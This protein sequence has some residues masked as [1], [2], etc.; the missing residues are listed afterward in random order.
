MTGEERAAAVRPPPV[1]G[2]VIEPSEPGAGEPVRLLDLSYDPAGD[3][4]ALH[5]WDFGDGTTS[6]EARPTHR[7]AR[8]GAYTVTLHVTALDGRVAVTSTSVAVVTHD[9]ALTRIRA[10]ERA[11]AGDEVTVVVTIES[12][13]GAEIVQIDLFRQRGLGESAWETTGIQTH[14]IPSG[15]AV[16]VSFAVPFDDEDAKA[17]HVIFGA[18]AT[19]VGA[20]DAAPEDNEMTASPTIVR[21]RRS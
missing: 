6:V 4:I 14:P 18:R 13:R 12:R 5:A 8:D 10:P 17:G 11:R 7:Y 3:G 21:A 20:S 2:F 9:V 1:A 16:D 15:R 19:I